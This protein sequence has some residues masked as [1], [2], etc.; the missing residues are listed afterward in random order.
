MTARDLARARAQQVQDG[1]LGYVTYWTDVKGHETLVS[2]FYNR[3]IT[4]DEIAKF[5]A[6]G[7][8]YQDFDT[9]YLT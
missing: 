3:P 4:D 9:Y 2:N 1:V 6:K 5:V 8:L 7:L